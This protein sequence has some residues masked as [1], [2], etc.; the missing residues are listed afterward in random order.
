[1]PALTQSYVHGASAAPLIGETIGALLE[2][3]TAEGPDRPALVTR[4]QGVRWTYA[5]LNRRVDDLAAGLLALDLEPGDRIGVWSP[6]ASEWVLTQFATAKAGMILVNINPAYR[7]HEAEYALA[8]VG[9]KALILSPGFKSNDYFASLRALAPEIDSATPGALSATRLPQLRTVIRLGGEKTAGMLNFAD[10]AAPATGAQ[11][12]ALAALG[13]RLQFDDPINIQFTS[14]TTGAPKGA[15]LTHHN[16]VNNGFFIDEAMRLTPADRLCIPV[17]YYHCFGMVLGNL[18]CVTH[19][20]CMV[21]PSEGFDPLATLETVAAER[22]TGLHGVPTMFIAMLDHPEFARFDLQSL[23]TGIMAGSPCPVEVMRRVVDQMHMSEVTIAYGMTETSPVSFQSACDDPLER[24]VSTVGRV[25]P[26]IEVKIV[27]SQGRIVP[28]G[29]TGELLTRGYSVMRGYWGDPVGTAAAIDAARFMHTGD[30]ATI[31]AEGYCNIV[32][33]LKDMV[34]RGGEN[35]YPRE[36]EEFLYSHPAI[37]DVQ[38]FGVPDP[39][40]G[41]ELCAWIK[42]RDGAALS[43]AEAIAYCRASIAHYKAPKYV[44]FVQEFPMTV[45]GKV[46]KFQMRQAMIDALGL[47]V[48]K[49]A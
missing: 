33:R 34:I 22:C 43:E 38:V 48:E 13:E 20:A 15:T 1:M 23:R 11:L 2:R 31:D 26:H 25:Q 49:T 5:E 41:E 32:G 21:S 27:D 3:V 30:L 47:K 17:P 16:I 7:S 35:V 12:S 40:Y 6:N 46:Q 28:P 19:G 44:R 39:R 10:V 8:K 42:L 18:A 9:C 45:T 37:A 4:H 14:G 24:R 36:V 29:V